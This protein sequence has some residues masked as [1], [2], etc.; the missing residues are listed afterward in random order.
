MG[1][2]V[3]P[4]G[5]RLGVTRTWDSRWYS[6]KDYAK[7]LH[8]DLKLRSELKKKLYAAGIAKIEI[9]RAA[10]KVKINVHTARPGIVIG[11]KGAGV[12]QLRAEIQ[13]FSSAEIL[14]NIIEVKNPEANAQLISENVAAQLEKRVAFRRAMKKCMTAAFKQGIK[15]IKIRVAGR[16][17]GA[18]IARAEWYSEDSVPLHTL[19]ANVDYGTAQAYTVYGVIGVKVWVYHGETQTLKRAAAAEAKALAAGGDRDSKN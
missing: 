12:D 1:Q 19:R 8:E 14:L 18:E 11:K 5:F 2:K 3:H 13:K 10:N 9:E 16:L 6:K 4:I 15:G 7:L 17:G